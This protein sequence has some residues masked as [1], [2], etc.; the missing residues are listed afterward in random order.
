MP[1]EDGCPYTYL[2]NT[3][4]YAIGEINA[5]NK[6]GF[7]F[8]EIVT[9]NG[10]K[11]DTTHL[12]NHQVNWQQYL[13][14]FMKINMHEPQYDKVY[15]MSQVLDTSGKSVTINFDAIYPNLPMQKMIIKMNIA[16]NMISSIYAETNEKKWSGYKRQNL[17]YQPSRL[18]QIIKKEK[19]LLQKEESTIKNLYFQSYLTLE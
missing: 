4:D 7:A 19:S 14:E 6:E 5:L 12:K 16:T 10:V 2:L 9:R 13:G 17:L 1:H 8:Q 18:I 3:S 15:T 11:E